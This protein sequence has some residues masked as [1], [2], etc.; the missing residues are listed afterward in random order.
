MLRTVILNVFV[1]IAVRSLTTFNNNNFIFRPLKPGFSV[2]DDRYNALISLLRAFHGGNNFS[3]TV[4]IHNRNEDL[5][6]S[7]GANEKRERKYDSIR[8]NRYCCHG[9]RIVMYRYSVL[10]DT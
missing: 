9:H 7:N 6:L 8:E 5:L 3:K 2:N 4:T 10:N 1:A